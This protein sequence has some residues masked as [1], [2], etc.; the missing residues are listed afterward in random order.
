MEMKF[1]TG[2]EMKFGIG[3]EIGIGMEMEIEIEIGIGTGSGAFE[4]AARVEARREGWTYDPRSTGGSMPGDGR[5]DLRI[6]PTRRPP[7]SCC[8]GGRCGACC[9]RRA[10]SLQGSGP[11][12]AAGGNA[13]GRK[14]LSTC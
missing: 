2:I 14:D 8:P 10:G 6:D 13:S 3:M 5:F 9:A 7:A 4:R 11:S 12:N 1:G